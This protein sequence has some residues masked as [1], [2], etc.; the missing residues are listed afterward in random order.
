[1]VGIQIL[2]E[3]TGQPLCLDYGDGGHLPIPEDY[4]RRALIEDPRFN[5]GLRILEKTPVGRLPI[6]I[7]DPKKVRGSAA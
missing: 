1:M 3:Y 7:C 2:R 4:K 6:V 5:S